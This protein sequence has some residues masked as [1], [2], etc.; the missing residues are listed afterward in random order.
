[1]EQDIQRAI[2]SAR[3]AI[4]SLQEGLQYADHG[5]YGQDRERIRKL[6]QEL[7]GLKNK[8]QDDARRVLANQY[9]DK[10]LSKRGLGD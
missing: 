1:M 4:R 2:T 5:A 3:N 10:E 8:E 6:R 7:A 9:I